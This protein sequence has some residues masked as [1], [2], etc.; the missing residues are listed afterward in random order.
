MH[1]YTSLRSHTGQFFAFIII[2]LLLTGCPSLTTTEVNDN[3]A[4]KSSSY[5]MTKMQNSLGIEKTDWQ[6]LTIRALLREGNTEKARELLQKLPNSFAEYQ[7]QEVLLTVAEFQLAK[8]NTTSALNNLNQIKL[9]QLNTYQEIRYKLLQVQ[10]MPKTEPLVKLRAYIELEKVIKQPYQHQLVSNGVWNVLTSIPRDKVN[11][12]TIN[13]D[14]EV[15]R[16]WLDLIILYNDSNS[17]LKLLEENIKNWQRRYPNNPLAITLPKQLTSL[18]SF[19][20]TNFSQ[21]ALLL[22]MSE[23]T[24]AF[25]NAIQKGLM[26][27]IKQDNAPVEVNVIDTSNRSIND[28]MTQLDNQKTTLVIG[29]LLKNDV[30]AISQITSSINILALN[31][32]EYPH[33]KS[34]I[35]YFGLS[36]EDEA[37]DAARMIMKTGQQTPLLL[38]PYNN[39]G[40]RVAFAFNDT[41]T[42]LGGQ[43]TL[44]QRFGSLEEL[45]NL[46]N[47]GKNIEIG[48]EPLIAG[49]PQPS[50]PID[51]IYIL[52]N[53][54]ELTLIKTMLDMKV[55]SRSKAELYA[56]SRSNQANSSP[57]FRLDM[58]GLKF[59]EIPLLA[60]GNKQLLEQAMNEFKNDYTKIRLFALGIDAWNVAKS[61]SEIRQLPNFTI[62]GATGTL[63]SNNSCII[64]RQLVWL[65]FKQ[66]RLNVIE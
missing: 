9:A 39:L 34:N 53:T 26:T 30:D 55:T 25:S 6:L 15:L 19:K 17:D 51:A 60:G 4:D 43:T 11:N 47:H 3:L 49:E 2:T 27:A 65:Q 16:G 37:R 52:A 36:P 54:S 64:N 48:G 29:P 33:I 63:T 40:D 8:N 21:I 20:T 35:C 38:I 31:T 56:S 58:D 7:K 44:V 5:Y 61:M 24:L 18:L 1:L 14:E 59:S 46:V 28:I 57:D 42:K 32:P 23:N 12:L 41:W 66:G 13:A 45:S 50:T 22:P 62:K 10:L